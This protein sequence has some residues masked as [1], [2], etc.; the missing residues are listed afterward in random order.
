MNSSD[1]PSSPEEMWTAYLDGKL[2][3]ADAAAFEREHPEAAAEREMHAQLGAAIRSHSRTPELRN[4]E[5]FNERILR[6]IAPPPVHAP[7]PKGTLWSL[8]RLATAG[9]FCFLGMGAI[10]FLAVRDHACRSI[11]AGG[12]VPARYTLRCRNTNEGIDWMGCG[13]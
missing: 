8:W 6:E 9:A 5:F 7:R 13:Y 3:T 10:Y 12:Q 4:A 11:F 1:S 2:A